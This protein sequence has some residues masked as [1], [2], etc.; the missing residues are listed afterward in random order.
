MSTDNSGKQSQA[1][2]PPHNCYYRQTTI[3]YFERGENSFG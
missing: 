3:E 2:V 1:D